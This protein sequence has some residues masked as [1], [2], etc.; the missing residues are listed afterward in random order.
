MTV[1]VPSGGS[2]GF[3]LL[4][5]VMA[6]FGNRYMLRQFASGNARTRGGVPVLRLET[7]GAR[8]GE[9]RPVVL[10]YL[11]EPDAWLVI[12]ALAGAAR[13]P[14]WLHNLGVHPDATVEPGDGTRVRVRA[15]TLTGDD[16]AAAWERIAV[17]APEFVKYRA[18]TDREI[19]VVRLRR[20]D[21]SAADGAGTIPSG[22]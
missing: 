11:V 2:R 9:P 18:T 16:L 15:E 21:A 5:R 22:G 8:S 1:K 19:A 20:R 13:N 3:R 6:R 14:A 12:A 10:G 17:E 4:P 7:T